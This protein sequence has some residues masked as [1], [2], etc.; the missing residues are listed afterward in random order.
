VR[1]KGNQVVTEVANDFDVAELNQF[2]VTKG[3]P[4]TEIRL[5]KSS[6]EEKF[7]KLTGEGFEVVR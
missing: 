7:V 5:E 6:L 2:L 4:V 1:I 3:L